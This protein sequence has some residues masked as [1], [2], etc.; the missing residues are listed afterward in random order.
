MA[1]GWTSPGGM[2]SYAIVVRN[3]SNVTLET[4]YATDNGTSLTWG[5]TLREYDLSTYAGQTIRVLFDIDIWNAPVDVF[6]DG[7]AITSPGADWLFEVPNT[8][9][10]SPGAAGNVAVI[11]ETSYITTPADNG[12]EVTFNTFNAPL[13]DLTLYLYAPGEE[14]DI[15]GL[16]SDYLVN[17]TTGTIETIIGGVEPDWEF[18]SY[19]N[20]TGSTG[21]AVHTIIADA[22]YLDPGF[23][24]AN[25]T[26]ASNDPD[27]PAIIIPVNLTVLM[28]LH[29]IKV[30]EMVGPSLI[31]LGDSTIIS[32][33]ITNQGLSSES[34][35][36][37]F[38]ENGITLSSQLVNI[39]SGFSVPVIF[40]YTPAAAGIFNV[41]IYAVP[42]PGET[43]VYNNA[44]WMDVEVIA[45]PEIVTSHSSMLIVILYCFLFVS[46]VRMAPAALSSPSFVET[47]N[48]AA[49]VISLCILSTGRLTPII[50]VDAVSIDDASIF[51]VSAR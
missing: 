25:I 23:Y 10:I 42:V 22:T 14:I 6:I 49:A 47:S 28:P 15:L 29:D 33:I 43:I 9:F 39:D 1:G 21:P 11:N 2:Q 41:S 30:H 35:D 48:C 26:V 3:T 24:Q 20:Y 40:N 34:V 13:L 38:M 18:Y 32:A 16:G 50:P 17:M 5:W 37:W 46:V 12:L 27:T 45:I 36:V 7:V 19:Y 44:V 4:L 8:G 31:S 51:I